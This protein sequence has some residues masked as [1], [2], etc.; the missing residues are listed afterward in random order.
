MIGQTISHYKILEKLGEGGMGVVYKAEDTK[1]ERIVALKFLPSH[2][3][4]SEQEKARFVHEA[5]AAA[6]LDHSNIC[7]IY[8]INEAEGQT[9]ISMAYIEGQSL[10]DKIESGQ[11]SLDESLDITI[12]VVE[13]LKEAHEHGVVHR[14]IKPANIMITPKG[15]T[16]I[17][18][19]G[20]AKIAGQTKVTKAG[21]TVGTAAYMSPEQA[22]GQD[23]DYRSD[24][25]SLGVVLYEML[26]GEKPFK[27]EFDA[28][29]A[30]S[31][32]NEKPEQL[33]KF[34]EQ[35]PEELG[36]IVLKA[37]EKD[38]EKRFQSVDEFQQL[39]KRLRASGTPFE[40]KELGFKTLVNLLRRPRIALVVSAIVVTLLVAL[41]VPY[42][43]L[44]RNQHAQ[45]LL[46]R[47]EKM[48]DEGR[49]YEAY[50][51]AAKVENQ[52]DSDSTFMR[53]M[54]I[55]ADRLTIITEPEAARVFIKPFAP[56]NNGAFSEREYIGKTPIRDMQIARGDYHVYIKKEGY[57]PVER[58]ASSKLL[59]GGRSI[60][61][62][63]EIESK[64]PE[65][66]SMPDNMVFVPEGKY[67]LVGWGLPTTAEVRLDDYLV[68]KYE[69]SN[70]QFEDFVEA[71]GYLKKKYWRY[72]FIKDNKEISWEEAMQLLTDRTGL[73]GPRSWVSQEFPEGKANHPVTAITWYEA[74]AYASFVG[75][76][77]PTIFQWEK[78]ARNGRRTPMGLYMPWGELMFEGTVA[79][80]ANFESKGT[81]PIEQYEFG[82]SPYGCYNMAGN[83]KEW[84]LNEVTGRYIAAGG[85]WQDPQYTFGYYGVYAGFYSS[86][87][88]GF[89]CISNAPNATG[90]QGAMKID[91]EQ[92]IPSYSPVDE[93]TFRGFLSHYKY[94]KKPL[95][96]QIIEVQETPDWRKEKVS[97]T[98]VKD[99]R[100]IA[101]LYLPKKV[102]RPF[103]CIN[104]SPFSLVFG[105][106]ASADEAAEHYLEP[107]IKSGRAVLAIVPKGAKEREWGPAY[108]PPEINTVRYR[109]LAVHR[110]TEF[111]IGLDYLATRNDIDMDK[112]A[113]V[114][115]SPEGPAYIRPAVD[116]RYR[117]VIFWG[118][119]IWPGLRKAL[120]EAN[121]INFIPYINAPALLLNGRYDEVCNL[122]TEAR[123]FYDLL[124][125]PKK[126]ALVDGGHVP[127][128]E[129]TVP[130]INEWLDNTLGPVKFRA[131]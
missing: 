98:G 23:V 52:L 56:D 81:E 69:V 48:A 124:R 22:Q 92:R 14:D 73:P 114:S 62:G 127:R 63:I 30:Y 115:L 88:M 54:P 1:L 79:H 61:Q 118:A 42:L 17:M 129:A 125:Q 103:H 110:A 130:I 104:F 128:L 100:I 82:V 6:A 34:G 74:A 19:F 77:L 126:L 83:V 13:G 113:Y 7:T 24:I 8:E 46:P 87:S 78:A 109:E 86:E 108:V 50:Q 15:Q 119:G 65:A 67:R 89:R 91:F 97:I 21:T 31:I 40:A 120:P 68:D 131:P 44:L 66:E 37:L 4:A 80:R 105:G 10:K 47:I 71:G 45:D 107:Q 43:R 85:S 101:Y 20:V 16:K 29:V 75:K 41:L 33:E 60:Y 28:A 36:L 72:P 112:L 90:D 3:L 121:P 106:G 32:L 122:E 93:T 116:T 55:I 84:C 95:D 51:L 5:Q 70:N 18:D 76:A 96:P 57:V 2:A 25:W 38:R 94:D 39:L 53:L 123:P 49:Y 26:T 9:F 58:I 27:G 64:L 99:E 11:L 102:E 35:I 12:Q 117:S 111:S 59:R